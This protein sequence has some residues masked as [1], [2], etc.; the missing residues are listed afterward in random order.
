M[1]NNDTVHTK[2]K[3]IEIDS[4]LT[5]DSTYEFIRKNKMTHKYEDILWYTLLYKLHK[6]PFKYQ[7]L[8]SVF[9]GDEEML[10]DKLS[11]LQT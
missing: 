6:I 2:I 3:A 5:I 8:I 4:Y 10:L 11:A 1:S 9:C 7:Y